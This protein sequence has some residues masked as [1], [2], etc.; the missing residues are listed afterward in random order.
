M[1]VCLLLCRP[2][3]IFHLS[4]DTLQYP[5]QFPLMFYDFV[6]NKATPVD[7]LAAGYDSGKEFKPHGISLLKLNGVE[8]GAALLAVVNHA[9]SEGESRVELFAVSDASGSPAGH[10][11][12]TQAVPGAERAPL[13]ARDPLRGLGLRHLGSVPGFG[14]GTL[15]DVVLIDENTFFVTEWYKHS[16][17]QNGAA[18]PLSSVLA[19]NLMHTVGLPVYTLHKCSRGAAEGSAWACAGALTLPSMNGVSTTRQRDIL[20]VVLIAAKSVKFYS[21]G[22]DGELALLTTLQLP[23]IVDNLSLD[24]SVENVDV[25]VWYG[26]GILRGMDFLAHSARVTNSTAVDPIPSAEVRVTYTRSSNQA[27]VEVLRTA[28]G[29]GCW[30][31]SVK[32]PA[33]SDDVHTRPRTIIGSFC[34]SG[35]YVCQ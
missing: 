31:N 32:I 16:W 21:I 11:G 30:C 34:S 26:A 14:A 8:A 9:I 25:D 12:S 10:S 15:N 23:C 6:A 28:R 19:Q 35:V 7:M 3:K 22:A 18:K 4:R 17:P 33:S 1:Y 13:L 20:A 2:Y 29:A 27:T 5:Q 24:S